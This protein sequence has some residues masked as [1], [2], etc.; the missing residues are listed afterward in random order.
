MPISSLVKIGLMVEPTWGSGGSPVAMYPVDEG[1]VT[2]PYEAI[3]DNARRGV[4]A[5]DFQIY[6]G[7]GRAEASLDGKVFTDIFG[8]IL[9]CAFGALSTSGA[10]PYEHTFTFSGTPPSLC[11]LDDVSVRQNEGMGMMVAEL[12]FS[13]TPTEGQ[14]SFSLS[15]EGKQVG[16]AN[17]YNW[18]GAAADIHADDPF[19][20]GWQGSVALDGT[21]FPVVEAD[22]TITREITLHYNLQN[23]QYAG[24][25]YAGAP[26]I[27]GAFTIDFNDVGDWARYEDFEYGSVDVLY[28]IDADNQLKFELGSVSFGEGP[29]EIDRSGASLTMA[30]SWRAMYVPAPQTGPARAILTCP[31]TTTF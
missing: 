31:N 8:Y 21:F 15:A 24:T 17:S 28:Y 22:F 1:G 4:V 30:Y 29:V 10:G 7:I 26:E 23:T 3:L 11:I 12:G 13:F 25:A 6:Q 18:E 14:L 5:K 20:L 2:N 16:T 19:F 9:K 27:T